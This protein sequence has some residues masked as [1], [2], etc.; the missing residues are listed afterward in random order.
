MTNPTEEKPLHKISAKDGSLIHHQNITYAVKYGQRTLD[1]FN[2]AVFI[3]SAGVTVGLER[4][5]SLNNTFVLILVALV[6]FDHTIQH[7]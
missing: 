2:A 1:R 4:Y 5:L 3:A 6:S 7:L